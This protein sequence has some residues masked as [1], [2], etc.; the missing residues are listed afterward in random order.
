MAISTYG[1]TLSWGTSA[2]SLQKK[3]D[4]KDFPDLGG[5]PELIETTTLS[6]RAQAYING[7]QSMDAFEFTYNYTKADFNA[8]DEDANTPLY[9]EL[10]LGENNGNEGIFTWQGEHSTWVTGGDVNA[11]VEGKISIAPST[12]PKLKKVA[13]V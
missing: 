4:I 1:V 13:G 3:I 12:Q 9:Y 10:A 6:Q 8:V 11:V 2:D 7:V 5:A